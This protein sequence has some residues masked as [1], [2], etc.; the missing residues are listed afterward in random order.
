[1]QRVGRRGSRGLA[2]VAGSLALAV[3]VAAWT[4]AP[5]YVSRASLRTRLDPLAFNGWR[6]LVA[7][8][9]TLP[10]AVVLEGFPFTTPWLDPVFEAGVWVGGVVASI[11]G[12]G[13]FVYSV[14][15]V[16]AGVALP[17]A[18]LF[19]VW[20]ALYD[21]ARGEAGIWVLVA[22]V[23]AVTGIAVV[24]RSGGGRGVTDLYAIAAAVGASLVWGGSMYAYQAALSRAGF[25]S[26]AE[27][28]A[29]FMTLILLPLMLRWDS[30][31]LV[32]EELVVS[33][34]LGYVVGA[35]A[36]LKAL[37]AMPA[38]IVA[39]G[40]A[41]TPVLTQLLSGRVASEHVTPKLVAGG[42]LVA[43]GIALAQLAQTG[44]LP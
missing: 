25:L 20:T 17:T 40:L 41:A 37:E 44:V 27:A 35:V 24:A 26:V 19:V 6:M 42:A 16:G 34:L 13:L 36:F 15:R 7:A 2:D 29:L 39:L 28:R 10:A 9:A 33:S 32:K 21:Y 43:A 22:S 5:L 12:D 18:Y 11:V 3:A 30:W 23:L 8:L 1:L 14:S 31:R 4:L 38:S